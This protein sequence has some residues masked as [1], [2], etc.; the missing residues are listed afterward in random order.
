MYSGDSEN[1]ISVKILPVIISPIAIVMFLLFIFY[2]FPKPAAH[3]AKSLATAPENIASEKDAS[4]YWQAP[5]IDNIPVAE[6]K[7]Q[8]AYG[9]D[10]IAHTALYFGP[11]GS[12]SK[13]SNGLNCQNCHLQAGTA[14]YGNNYGSVASLYPKFRA[15]SGSFENI[16]KRV[17]DCFIRSLNGHAID[18]TG[19]EMQAITAYIN[20]L[21]SNVKK[22]EKAAGSGFKELAFMD[23][24]AN[25]QKGK[26]VYIVRCQSCHQ[27]NGDGLIKPDSSEYIYPALWGSHS[28]NDGAGLYR[29]GNMAKFIKYNMPQGISFKIPMLSD[30]EAWNV[31]AFIA[32]QPRPHKAVPKD[33]PDKSAKPLDHPFGPYADSF[34][35]RQH[36]LGPFKPIVT[37][38][39]QREQTAKNIKATPGR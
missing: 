25:P 20:F 11:H 32:V 26:A 37:A 2:D 21:G 13:I 31:A 14:V 17:N 6:T 1:K 39:Q 5:D 7:Q 34:T 36:K 30:E 18:T 8:I 29:L 33:W 23:S 38:Q 9:K 15:R 4:L 22:G 24:A 19:R 28:F 16:Y 27:Q 3:K 12:V 35:A 10:L